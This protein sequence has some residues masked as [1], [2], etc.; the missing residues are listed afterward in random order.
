M[1]N[2]SSN[3]QAMEKKINKLS[4]LGRIGV[5]FGGVSAE[6]EVSLESGQAVFNALRHLGADAVAIDL[7]GDVVE[8]ILQANINTAFI[9]LHGGIG[10]DGRLQALLELLNIPYAGSDTQSSALAMNKLLSK[11][12]WKGVGVAT[13]PFVVLSQTTDFEKAM[14]YLGGS[15]MVKPAHEGSSIGMGFAHSA[16]ELKAAYQVAAE[17]DATVLAEKV[18]VGDEYTIAIVNGEALP[19]IKLETDRVFYDYD[20]KYRD[21]TTRYICPCGLNDQETEEIK[22]LALSAFNSLQCSGWGRVDIMRDENNA[23]N[24]LEVNT[25]PGMTSHSLVPMAAKAAGYSFDEL[26]GEIIS[27]LAIAD[28]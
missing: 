8:K 22:Q 26:V 13:S 7:T 17:Y 5:L 27:P 25:V 16:Q 6:R 19:V 14:D 12:L 23:F 3:K 4:D 11:Q 9:V 24:V 18:L 21:N 20:A 10:E 28:H 15:A 2:M 1:N